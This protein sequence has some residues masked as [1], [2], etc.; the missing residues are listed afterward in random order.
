[1]LKLGKDKQPVDLGDNFSAM[2]AMDQASISGRWNRHFNIVG[3]VTM[4][5]RTSNLEMVSWHDISRGG[6]AKPCK[7]AFFGDHLRGWK[8]SQ[9]YQPRL[10]DAEDS[11]N[12][13]NLNVDSCMSWSISEMF[14]Y[15][16]GWLFIDVSFGPILQ[17]SPSTKAEPNARWIRLAVSWLR[18]W[19]FCWCARGQQVIFGLLW[20][21]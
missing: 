4:C 9:R 16:K 17:D 8:T 5:W 18:C 19:A 14:L 3:K 7:W 12:V 21:H 2:L 15:G 20:P 1:M 11:L 10:T 13:S 6:G